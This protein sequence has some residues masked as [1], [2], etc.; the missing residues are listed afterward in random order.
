MTS[1]LKPS[2][3][4][5]EKLIFIRH[6]EKPAKGLGLLTCKGINRSLKLPDFF[7]RNFST[8]DYIFAPNPLVKATEIHGDGQRYYYVRPIL[9]IGPTAVRLGVPINTELPY[10]DPGLIADTLLDAKYHNATI[11]LC[12]EHGDLVEF[13]NVML[14]RFSSDQKVPEWDNDNY[15]MVFIFT[16]DWTTDRPTLEFTTQMQDLGPISNDCP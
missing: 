1:S 4:N 16:I 7:S 6:G 11:F 15:D 12:W 5:I 2:K 13:A 14:K 9:T 8:P 3:E 10:N